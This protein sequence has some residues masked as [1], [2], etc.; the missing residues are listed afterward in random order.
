MTESVI[1]DTAGSIVGGAARWG[2]ELD[3]FM[4]AQRPPVTVIGRRR[5]LTA[6]WLAR[7]ERSARH[8]DLAVAANNVSFVRAGAHRRV[9]LR[10]PL[11]FVYPPENRLLQ[12]MP[13][14][15][16]AQVPVVHRLARRA[17]TLIVPT[18]AMA[19][20]VCWHLPAVRDRIVVRPHPVMPVG[21]RHPAERPFILA[22]VLPS[23]FKNIVTQLRILL[24]GIE[25]AGSAIEVRI[26][27]DAADLPTDLVGHPSLITLGRLPHRVLVEFWR[28]A[29]AVFFPC[30][31]ESFGYPLAEARVYGLPVLAPDSALAREV[32]GPAL[33]PYDP[34]D[35]DSVVAALHAADQPVA[36]DGEAFDRDAYFRWLFELPTEQPAPTAEGRHGL[37]T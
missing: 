16:R 8:A 24:A 31:L 28:S 15:L 27:A 11:H 37:P 25:H 17:E 1:V 18:S 14:S 4:A 29:T 5:P 9:L 33:R 32:A 35:L 21:S 13:R 19:E 36:P 30:A 22:P 34:A 26:T 3:A 23:P 6:G 10:N 2:E 20:R 12:R 7:R